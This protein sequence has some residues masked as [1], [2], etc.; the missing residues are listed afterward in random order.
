MLSGL[1][2]ND[3]LI[4]GLGNDTL[5]GGTGADYFV[6]NTTPNGILN[7]DT[8]TDFNVVDDTIRLENSIFTKLVTTGTLNSSMFRSGAGITTAGDSND[9][10]I[11]NTTSG[12]LYYDADANG[13]AAAVQIALIGTSTHAALT[14]ADFVVI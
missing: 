12:V 6:F 8:I 14:N 10:I 11:Y 7:K 4:G 5:T 13:A 1:G 9:Y 2:G 3:T